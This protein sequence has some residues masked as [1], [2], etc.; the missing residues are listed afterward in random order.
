MIILKSPSEIAL[1]KKSGEILRDFFEAVEEKVKPGVTTKKLD[2]FAYDFI[3]RRNATPSFLNY[4]GYPASIC[5]S[6]DEVVVHGIPSK[7][8]RLEEGQIIGIDIGA[9]LNG[10]QSDAARTY[11]VG[12]VS[13]EKKKLV[14]VTKDSFFE[15]VKQFK[16]GG[17]LGDISEAVQKYAES[18]GYGVIRAMVGH[19]IGRQMHEDP[20]VP[21]YGRAGHGTKLEIGMVLAIEPMIS[22]GSWEVKTLTD[23]WTCVTK[24]SSP[25]AHYENTVALTENGIQILTL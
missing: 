14:E 17:R 18:R 7:D 19:G 20:Q 13:E 6:I 22:M 5:A 12:D 10:W 16:D 1:M 15:G 24:D 25:S 3:K 21:N 9:I 8:R 23:G 11:L 2:E 4:A